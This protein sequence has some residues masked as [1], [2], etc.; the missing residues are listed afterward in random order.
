M[1]KDRLQLPE[2]HGDWGRPYEQADFPDLDRASIPLRGKVPTA[3]LVDVVREL[4][5]AEGPIH[6]DV[7][8]RH[9]RETLRLSSFPARS[10]NLVRFALEQLAENGEITHGNEFLDQAGRPCRAARWQVPNAVERPLEHVATAERQ[11][12]LMGLIGESPGVPHEEVVAEAAGFFGWSSRTRA[13]KS[14]LLG[15]L[16]RLRDQQKI[17][18]WPDNLRLAPGQGPG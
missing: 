18:G 5:S 4:I 13:P 14:A 3:A 1:L 15:D 17:A 11:V 10:K 12:A 8:F 16:Y 6:E 2:D 7:F 9:F